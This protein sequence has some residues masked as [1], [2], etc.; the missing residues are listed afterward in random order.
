MLNLLKTFLLASTTCILLSSLGFSTQVFAQDYLN[1]S[2]SSLT[3]IEDVSVPLSLSIDSD[4][5]QGGSLQ[6]IIATGTGYRSATAGNTPTVSSIPE[7]A[8]VAL[9]TGYSTFN[10]DNTSLL[11]FYND[12]YQILNVNID[13]LAGTSSGR[14]A[15]IR[16]AQEGAFDQFS[17]RQVPLGQS[18]LSDTSLLTGVWTGNVDLTFSQNGSNIEIVEAHDLQTAYHFEYLSSADRS[19]NFIR[20]GSAVQTPQDSSS[21]L[22]LPDELEPADGSNGYIVLS[23]RSGSGGTLGSDPSR[24]EYKGF[25]RLVID[26]ETDTISGVISAERGETDDLTIT[27]A[28]E[29]YPLVDLRDDPTLLPASI[30]STDSTN[31]IGDTVSDGN[32]GVLHDPTVYIDTSGQLVFERT[33][34]FAASFTTMITAEYYERVEFSSIATFIESASDDALFDASPVDDVD[35]D[36]KLINQL[37]TPVPVSSRVG[38]VQLAFTTIG[39]TEINENVGTGFAVLDI[40]AGTSSGSM[41]FMRIDQPDHL[42][43]DAVPFGTTIASATDADGTPLFVSNSTSGD[44]IDA[45]VKFANFDLQTLDDG[46]K[47]LIFTSSNTQGD[48]DFRDY[49]ANLNA[50]WLGNEPFRISDFP[51][52]GTFSHGAPNLDGI[53]EIDASD[54]PSLSFVPPDNYAGSV[55]MNFSLYSTGETDSIQINIAPVADDPIISATNFSNFPEIDD[56]VTISITDSED[57]DGSETQLASV[58]LNGVP[59]DVTLSASTGSISN[60]SDGVWSVSRD[61]LDTLQAR[62]LIPGSTTVTVVGTNTDEV[63]FDSDIVLQDGEDD[64]TD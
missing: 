59:S 24:I 30:T 4:L 27:Y 33:S 62:G 20:A 35:D 56:D 14:I 28:F 17:W 9:I 54:I 48:Q 5:L 32:P 37:T 60:N 39:G 22:T 64:S 38:I 10:G 42:S 55:D 41:T 43:W 47:E 63:S 57:T 36:N 25:G 11:D 40:E 53:W 51:V 1:V 6:D 49:R 2:S 16:D 18:I 7:N 45:W 15:Q 21:S 29:G 58:V 19:A 8:S 34:D 44:Y 61:A 12:D 52:T 46:S 26:L 50:F 23:S 13:L 3:G 31:I